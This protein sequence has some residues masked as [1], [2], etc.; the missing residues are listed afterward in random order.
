MNRKKLTNLI[1]GSLLIIVGALLLGKY[2][3]VHEEHIERGEIIS[4]ESEHHEYYVF[5]QPEGEGEA[6]KL[7]VEDELTWNLVNEGE[8]YNVAYAWHGSKEPKIEEMEKV[9]RE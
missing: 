2:T 9:E 7:V 6:K 4:K 1:I 8:L 5:V 3:Y